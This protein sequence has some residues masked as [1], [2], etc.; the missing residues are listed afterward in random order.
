MVDLGDGQAI[1][2]LLITLLMLI[3]K[4]NDLLDRSG[5]IAALFIGMSVSF[6][7]H[8]T[9][10]AVLMTFL[11]VGAVSTKWRYD[12]KS[13]K[14]TEEPDDGVRGWKN[15]LANGGIATSVAVFDFYIGGHVWS[16]LV[17]CSCVSVATAD[18][19]AS[20]IGRL[21]PRTRIITTLEA[22]PAGTNGGM[23]PTGTAAAFYGALL[24]AIVSTILGAVNGDQTPPVF[25][26]TVVIG[27]GW[28]G[29]HMDSLLGAVLENRGYLGKHSVNFISTISG[30]AM[31]LMLAQRFL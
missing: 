25:M 2:L 5:L 9:W 13:E 12:E 29:C 1:S 14:S 15:V 17:M 10:L 31:T 22:V 24:I 21:D 30:V 27:V 18:T 4:A 3:S 26:F 6:L 19:L 28:L 7:G 11:I 8:W 20:E 23:S 16:Y